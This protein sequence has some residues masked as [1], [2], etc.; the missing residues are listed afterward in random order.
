MRYCG[1]R[2]LGIRGMHGFKRGIVSSDFEN[3]TQ[4]RREKNPSSFLGFEKEGDILGKDL[5]Y[6]KYGTSIYSDYIKD[7]FKKQNSRED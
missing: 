7:D 2:I 4:I 1:Y 3:E 6:P 5:F